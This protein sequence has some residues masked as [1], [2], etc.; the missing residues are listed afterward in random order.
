MPKILVTGGNGFIGS[1]TTV[2]L[3][4]KGF[5]VVIVDNLC[6][7]KAYVQERIFE[8]TGKKPAFYNFDLCSLE[9]VKDLKAKEGKFD[10]IIHFAAHLFVDESV[11]NPLKYY[12]N[13]FTS[14]MN[15]LEVFGNE[16]DQRFVFSSSCTVYGNPDALPIRENEA[17]KAAVSPY[18]NTKKVAEEILRDFAT[19]RNNF[20]VI[21][22]RYFNPIGAHDSGKIGED[23]LG[24]HV[25]LVPIIS[26]V[27]TGKRKA[28]KVFGNDYNTKDG[29]CVR[30]YLHVVDLAH[31][32]INALEY[33]LASKN[34]NQFE[35]Y[36]A[37]SGSG[38]TVLEIV[39][40]F[41][42]ASGI[43]INHE[44]AP[45]RD[46]DAEA[47]FADVSLIKEKL[48]WEPKHTLDQMLL[49]TYNW[50]KNLTE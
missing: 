12:Q 27:A 38:F 5:D 2:E 13:N 44:I 1:H 18:G 29:T 33:L 48:G 47:I 45:R 19:S 43:N 3:L 35:V 22:L 32:H 20:N 40:S 11:S 34:E 25:H 6:N 23:P 39:K 28:L 17:V 21:S 7:S 46:G 36:N 41:E 30:D 15:L 16:P 8:L 31:A 24:H 50:E 14:L 10:G 49:S 26:E 42:K 37:G 4:N 9:A